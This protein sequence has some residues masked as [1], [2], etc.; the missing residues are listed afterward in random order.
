MLRKGVFSGSR[1]M[2][3]IRLW[4]FLLWSMGMASGWRAA[5]M[6]SLGVVHQDRQGQGNDLYVEDQ[7]GCQDQKRIE[8]SKRFHEDVYS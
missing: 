4:P 8:P 6:I 5:W 7:V 2:D 3:E 1:G